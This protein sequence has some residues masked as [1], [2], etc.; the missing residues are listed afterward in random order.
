MS[1]LGQLMASYEDDI[2]NASDGAMARMVE[3]GQKLPDIAV[4]LGE[5]A[6]TALAKANLAGETF[7]SQR[8]GIAKI[9][10]ELQEYGTRLRA[11]LGNIPTELQTSFDKLETLVNQSTGG[12]T[13][14]FTN[15]EAK[16]TSSSQDFEIS[17]NTMLAHLEEFNSLYEQLQKYGHNISDVVGEQVKSLTTSTDHAK[18][19][20]KDAREAMEAQATAATDVSDT[21]IDRM[22][23]LSRRAKTDVFD[24]TEASNTAL[25]SV[26]TVAERVQDK[27]SGFTLTMGNLQ[28]L[29]NNVGNVAEQHNALLKQSSQEAE[30]HTS[31]LMASLSRNQQDTF[32]RSSA[33]LVGQ[34]NQIAIDVDSVLEGNLSN[35]VLRA[36]RDGDKSISVRRLLGRKSNTMSDVR[37]VEAYFTN[38]SFRSKV[39]TYLRTFERLL[40]Q[41]KDADSSKLVH[42][43]FL[44]GDLGKLYIFLTESLSDKK[45]A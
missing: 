42:T 2:C 32:L 38:A 13:D 39:D 20:W 37:I 40:E 8:D 41:A 36:Y 9:A 26:E 28:H 29:I 25:A 44:T 16:I 23:E 43:A 4:A 1:K 10:G 15:L 12:M 19:A 33:E 45:A 5:S 6:E 7:E 22:E 24:L 31:K 35:D 21:Y 18:R 34:L 3:M 27:L 11:D 30:L 17:R 14:N